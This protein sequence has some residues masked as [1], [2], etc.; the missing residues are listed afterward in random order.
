[1]NNPSHAAIRRDQLPAGHC[2]HVS[3]GAAPLLAVVLL[4]IVEFFHLAQHA[5][6]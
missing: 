6:R 2:Q 3:A 1:M 4:I 5:A